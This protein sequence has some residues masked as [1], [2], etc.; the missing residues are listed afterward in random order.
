MSPLDKQL[1]GSDSETSVSYLVAPLCCTE[2]QSLIG[3]SIPTQQV[4]EEREHVD[5]ASKRY[6]AHH[7]LSIGQKQ[8][9][10]IYQKARGC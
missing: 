2:H 7:S 9:T 10:R 6:T 4:G 5:Q 8:V 3:T 1:S